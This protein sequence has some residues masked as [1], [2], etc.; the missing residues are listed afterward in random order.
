MYPQ[1]QR[2]TIRCQRILE[3]SER[4][5]HSHLDGAGERSKT[6]RLARSSRPRL[7]PG[8]S[9]RDGLQFRI[10]IEVVFIERF[11]APL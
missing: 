10:G 6:R 7:Q 5:Q 9:Q 3:L 2:Q 4:H 1:K 11:S 8:P